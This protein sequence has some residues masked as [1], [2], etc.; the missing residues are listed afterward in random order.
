L[1]KADCLIA[2]LLVA[3]GHER[4]FDLLL[5]AMQIAFGST[6]AQSRR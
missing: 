2:P 3:L 4:V 5:R 6:E 1:L